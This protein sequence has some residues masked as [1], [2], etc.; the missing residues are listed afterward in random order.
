[1]IHAVWE[2]LAA[3]DDSVLGDLVLTFHQ[4]RSSR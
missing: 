1:M 3:I 2:K 4:T